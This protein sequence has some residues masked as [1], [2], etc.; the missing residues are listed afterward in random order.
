MK[1]AILLCF[2]RRIFNQNPSHKMAWYC[3]GRSNSELIDNMCKAKIISSKAVAEEMK[4]VDRAN[5]VLNRMTAY[6]DSP[7]SIGYNATISAP[8]MHAMC[9]DVLQNHLKPGSRVLDVGSGSGY[10]VAVIAR[11][12]QPNGFVYG[13]EHIDQLVLW[14]REN[15]QKDFAQAATAPSQA[16]ALSDIKNAAPT[17]TK[18]ESVTPT[19]TTTASAN[20]ATPRNYEIRHSDGRDG[21]PDY[22]PFD[23]IH[24]GAASEQVP[25]ALKNQLKIGGRL[26]IPVGGRSGQELVL[27]DRISEKE[28]TTSNICGV[29]YIPLTDKSKQI[30]S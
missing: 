5:F 25:V 6:Q 4:M 29:V 1:R 27:I 10:L 24:V 8:H 16:M 18:S 17:G 20:I 7:Q 15:I 22:A 3:G 12:V 28:F 14:S 30:N 2:N 23:C 21:L 19:S 26:V 9:L 11:M 13:V